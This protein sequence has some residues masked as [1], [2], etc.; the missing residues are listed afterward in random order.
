MLCCIINIVLEI[1]GDELTIY[2]ICEELFNMKDTFK[3]YLYLAGS[4]LS[5]RAVISSMQRS[6]LQQFSVLSI[7]VSLSLTIPSITLTSAIIITP[8]SCKARKLPSRYI[9]FTIKRHVC[10]YFLQYSAIYGFGVF[11]RIFCGK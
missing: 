11:H 6:H 4:L 10:Q 7:S 8:H 1:V 2:R 3:K 5:A 9:Y